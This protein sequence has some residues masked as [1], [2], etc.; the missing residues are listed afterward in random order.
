MR[1]G[2]G[3]DGVGRRALVLA[4]LAVAAMTAPGC[5][6]AVGSSS[7]SADD[8][9]DRLER[10]IEEAERRIGIDAAASEVQK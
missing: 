10:R 7:R 9:V 1:R 6:F 3:R 4:L 8:R 2:I 5:V